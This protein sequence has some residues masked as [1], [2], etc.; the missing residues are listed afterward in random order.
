M[1]DV[2]CYMGVVLRVPDFLERREGE[3]R[4][5]SLPRLYEKWFSG[6]ESLL[7]STHEKEMPHGSIRRPMELH[8]T[9]PARPHRFWAPQDS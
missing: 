4:R 2:C 3:V 9:P 6:G 1:S 5:T 8:R 7:Y